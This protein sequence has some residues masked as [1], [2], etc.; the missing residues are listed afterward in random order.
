MTAANPAATSITKSLLTTAKTCIPVLVALVLNACASV[1]SEPLPEGLTKQP[2]A[3]WVTRQQ[4]LS[5]FDHWTLQGKIAVRQREDSGSALINQWQQR[6]EQYHLVLSSA[7]LGMGR[8]ELKGT[9]GFLAL[10][11]SDG[12][13]YRS[14]EP[15]SLLQAATGWQLPVDSLAWWV[16]GLP[17]PEGDFELL[18]NDAG[19]LAAIRQ[20][21]WDIRIDKRQRFFP[22]QPPLPARITALN[23]ERR[24][25]LVITNWQ[26]PGLS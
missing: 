13:V 21:G 8:T 16:R 26:A 19:R 24:I 5:Q 23:G 12:E 6:G 25:R 14:S 4:A 17:A 9:P 7:F 22:G 1:P 3:D 10:T 18:F 2:P 20:Q 11:L 15:Q